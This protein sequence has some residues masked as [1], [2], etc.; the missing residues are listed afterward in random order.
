MDTGKPHE[1]APDKASGSSGRSAPGGLERE[2]D[3]GEA[4]RRALASGMSQAMRMGTELV[5]A[6]C[7]G[8]G[9]G[10]WLDRW[11]GTEPWMLLLFFLFGAAAGFRNLYRLANS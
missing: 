1:P 7:I 4:S 6:T 2:P 10:Y 5:V 3:P 9:M 11:M 8:L